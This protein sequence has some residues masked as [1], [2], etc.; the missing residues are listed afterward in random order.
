MRRA[1]YHAKGI[2]GED[3]NECGQPKRCRLKQQNKQNDRS[4][5][6]FSFRGRNPKKRAT[7]IRKSKKCPKRR[8][9]LITENFG[10]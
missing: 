6:K 7:K 5:R 8:S 4:R 10:Y 9:F 3:R 2:G 1:W